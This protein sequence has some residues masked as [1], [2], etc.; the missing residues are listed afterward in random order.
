MFCKGMALH[1]GS[2]T[3]EP[4]L[5]LLSAALSAAQICFHFRDTV[6]RLSFPPSLY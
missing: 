3:R 1:A 4:A 2:K 6:G 5:G